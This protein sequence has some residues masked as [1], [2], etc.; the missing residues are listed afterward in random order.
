VFVVKDGILA[1]NLFGIAA[2]IHP[3]GDLVVKPGGEAD[4]RIR[5][6]VADRLRPCAH[7]R[8]VAEAVVEEVPGLVEDD[9]LIL[10]QAIGSRSSIFKSLRC[11]R[12]ESRRTLDP[13]DVD[14]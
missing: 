10:R 9:L 5:N 14:R 1:K 8:C 11:V 3:V 7:D 12:W 4:W 13:V 6:P 2:C